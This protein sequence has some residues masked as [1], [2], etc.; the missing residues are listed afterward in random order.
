MKKWNLFDKLVY[1]LEY[2]LSKNLKKKKFSYTTLIS[3]YIYKYINFLLILKENYVNNVKIIIFIIYL[4]L[5]IFFYI[6]Y[7]HLFELL[8][9]VLI[10]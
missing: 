6:F 2:W 5:I 9:D 8:N 3:Q 1:L 4:R 10:I 7:T